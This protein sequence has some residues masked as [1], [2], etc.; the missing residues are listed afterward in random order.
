MSEESNALLHI[1]DD[2]PCCKPALLWVQNRLLELERENAALQNF[3][4]AGRDITHSVIGFLYCYDRLN[5]DSP[6]VREELEQM[7]R[8]LQKWD[9]ARKEAQP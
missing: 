8:D 6:V 2:H 7:R 5:R 1:A 3:Y 4:L 9:D